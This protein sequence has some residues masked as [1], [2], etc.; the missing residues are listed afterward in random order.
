MTN[1]SEPR[2]LRAFV[3]STYMDLREHRT[4][5]IDQLRSAGLAV[6]PMEVWTADSD[7]PKVFSQQRIESARLGWTRN[8]YPSTR[9]WLAG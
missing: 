6:D 9:L 4:F 1:P 8:P 3:S 5:V 2:Y 7:E